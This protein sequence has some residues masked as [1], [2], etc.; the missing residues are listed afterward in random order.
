MLIILALIGYGS[1]DIGGGG[2][3]SSEIVDNRRNDVV[4]GL[5]RRSSASERFP[6]FRIGTI[7]RAWKDI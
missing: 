4:S 2:N 5:L 7:F 3:D 1:I 6:N